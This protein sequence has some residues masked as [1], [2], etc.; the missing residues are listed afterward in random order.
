LTFGKAMKSV[1]IVLNGT[2][3]SGKTSIAQAILRRLAGIPILYVSLDHFTT[4]MFNWWSFKDPVV[5]REVFDTAVGNFHATLPILASSRFPIIV[6]HVFDVKGWHESCLLALKD[7]PTYLVG[8]RCPLSVLEEREKARKDRRPGLA[9]EQI[10][11]VHAGIDY[12][13]ELDTSI[14]TPDECATAVLKLLTD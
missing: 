9:R 4:G 1:A 2:S 3:S 10:D 5:G 8:V 6:D 13:L 12:S 7:K 14:Q 11:R